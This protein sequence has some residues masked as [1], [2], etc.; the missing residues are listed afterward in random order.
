VFV[1]C[2]LR[3]RGHPA[4]LL[5]RVHVNRI[6]RRHFGRGILP[7]TDNLGIGSSPPSPPELL[8]ELAAGFIADSWSSHALH[9]R[10]ITS[11]VYR[12]SSTRRPDGLARYSDWLQ[13]RESGLSTAH[14]HP[15]RADRVVVLFQ[16]GGPSQMDLFDPKPELVRM[17]GK[18]YPGGVKVETLSPGGSGNLLGS[19]FAFRP[20]GLSGMRLSELIPHIAPI[21]NDI[22]LVR[23]MTTE[24]VCHE[25]ALR[26]AHSGHAIAT[27]RPSFGSWLTYGLGSLNRN[28]PAFVVLPDPAGLP[29]NGT[30]NWSA[31]WLPA[32][33]QGTAFNAGDAATPPVLNLHT[34][35]R[36]S[37]AARRR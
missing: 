2:L 14:D 6:W 24:S 9:R 4:A 34:P 5:G 11:A 7:T 3:P 19:P 15:P 30:L 20:A 23:S 25:A 10:I 13:A 17:N 16:N 27:D 18:P 8:E 28:L 12:Q 35:G 29:I 32:Q 37:E 1:D 36:M 26:I 21:A 33:Y 31:G 22:T